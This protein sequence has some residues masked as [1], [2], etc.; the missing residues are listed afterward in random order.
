[1]TLTRYLIWSY[2]VLVSAFVV[3]GVAEK[4]VRTIDDWSGLL[5]VACFWPLLALILMVAPL[6]SSTPPERRQTF[7]SFRRSNLLLIYPIGAIT[8]LIVIVSIGE[9]L[10]VW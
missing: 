2:L 5:I 4:P 6:A 10:G 3:I 7:S 9:D 1:M 8:L